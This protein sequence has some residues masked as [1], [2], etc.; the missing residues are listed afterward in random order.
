M[1]SLT[2]LADPYTV[3]SSVAVTARQALVNAYNYVALPAFD[4]KTHR[5]FDFEVSCTSLVGLPLESLAK[6]FS[7]NVFKRRVQVL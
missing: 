3:F 6:R 1:L 7:R 5:S 4:H 2:P